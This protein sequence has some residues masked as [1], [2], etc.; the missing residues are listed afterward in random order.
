MRGREVYLRCPDG[1]GRSKLTN[2]YFESRLA[3]TTTIRNWRTVLKLVDMT[4]GA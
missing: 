3:T 4:A 1:F 2:D